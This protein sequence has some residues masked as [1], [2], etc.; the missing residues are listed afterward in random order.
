MTIRLKAF[1]TYLLFLVVAS[2]SASENNLT[3]YDLPSGVSIALPDDWQLMNASQIRQYERT[4]G[5]L[6]EREGIESP[7]NA[8]EAPVPIQ[9]MKQTRTSA[10]SA[11][12]T[13]LPG[14]ATQDEIVQWS[15]ND[16]I[17]QKLG[18]LLG[19]AQVTAMS[20]AGATDIKVGSAKVVDAGNKKAVNFF[21]KLKDSSG[22]NLTGDKYFIYTKDLTV[23][24]TFQTTEALYDGY[25]QEKAAIIASLSVD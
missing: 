25:A 4:R 7:V 14:E 11:M 20:A 3:T 23:I 2:A 1:L 5:N 17:I 6:L 12:I 22:R 19:N 13:Y 15:Q 9:A 16:E 18:E 10:V 8:D 21:M 24:L